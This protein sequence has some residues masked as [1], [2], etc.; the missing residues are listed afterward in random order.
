MS[1]ELQAQG[2]KAWMPPVGSAQEQAL[3]HVAALSV[4]ADVDPTLRVT[5]NFHP[6]RLHR[7]IPILQTLAADGVY[8]SQFETGTSN[9]GLTAHPGG[10]RWEWE[11][12][13]FDGAY[14]NAAP[15]ERP[16]YGSLNFR[17]RAVGVSP[18]FGSAHLRLTGE[19]LART[20]FC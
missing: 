8:R 14:D 16:K 4:G 3:T 2:P 19:V 10:D 1:T 5:L 6:D 13:L 15:Q 11:S 17:R 12:R 18:R 7:G 20:T 9:G